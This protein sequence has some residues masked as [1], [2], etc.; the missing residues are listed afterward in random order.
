MPLRPQTLHELLDMCLGGFTSSIDKAEG[1]GHFFK[2]NGLSNLLTKRFFLTG[3]A[4]CEIPS[5]WHSCLLSKQKCWMAMEFGDEMRR[6]GTHR[7]EI[8]SPPRA[9][10]NRA[11]RRPT[12]RRERTFRR[13]GLPTPTPRDPSSLPEMNSKVDA[14]IVMRGSRRRQ[15]A[16]GPPVVFLLQVAHHSGALGVRC[17]R[18]PRFR[19]AKTRLTGKNGAVQLWKRKAGF[20]DIH[21]QHIALPL[22]VALQEI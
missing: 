19:A 16:G 15:A 2:A 22:M 20:G 17:R 13:L 6:C 5:A 3:A 18:L 14:K 11:A 7:G 9:D 1:W 10:E 12:Y 8:L 4:L 21:I